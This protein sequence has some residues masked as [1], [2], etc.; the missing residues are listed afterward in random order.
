M[1]NAEGA[2]LRVNID[3]LLP[4]AMEIKRQAQPF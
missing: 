3:A 4:M 1:V 2:A